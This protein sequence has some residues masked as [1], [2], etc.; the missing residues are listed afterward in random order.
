MA[1]DIPYASPAPVATPE[2]GLKRGTEATVQALECDDGIQ[3]V[4]MMGA[5]SASVDA[6][7]TGGAGTL[8][9]SIG[10]QERY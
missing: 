4:K 5:D 1:I 9:A 8:A 2:Y 6:Y 10:W 3:L 7:T